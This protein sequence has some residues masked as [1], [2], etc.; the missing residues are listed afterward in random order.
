MIGALQLKLLLMW[1]LV[2]PVTDNNQDMLEFFFWFSDIFFG[3]SITC[4]SGPSCTCESD[5]I[6]SWSILMVKLSTC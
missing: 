5:V 2:E 4:G 6:H 1:N 3:I